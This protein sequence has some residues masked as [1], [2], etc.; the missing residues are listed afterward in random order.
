MVALCAGSGF[1][2]ELSFLVGLVVLV[3][4]DFWIGF[5]GFG[6]CGV[7]LPIAC[8][9]QFGVGWCNMVLLVLWVS[10]C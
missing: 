4:L 7:V 1:W 5:C 10:R 8:G 3:G 9:C 2:A 6:F